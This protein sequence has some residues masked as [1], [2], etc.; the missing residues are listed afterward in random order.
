MVLVVQHRRFLT[1]L[2]WT[3]K[4]GEYHHHQNEEERKRL[5]GRASQ[6]TESFFFS[7][8]LLTCVSHFIFFD[9]TTSR[10]LDFKHPLMVAFLFRASFSDFLFFFSRAVCLYLF[11]FL[12]ESFACNL[13]QANSLIH[14]TYY[15]LSTLWLANAK[16]YYS[17]FFFNV[18]FISLSKDKSAMKLKLNFRP[19][20]LDFRDTF[21]LV[22]VKRI[23][24]HCLIKFEFWCINWYPQWKWLKFGPCLAGRYWILYLQ[25]LV[26][27][28]T[29]MKCVTYI[30][31]VERFN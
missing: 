27:K 5:I 28:N 21:S 22:I 26:Y 24:W 8:S 23:L 14:K 30:V 15:K 6:Q 7:L 1:I 3:H 16:F 4:K 12:P 25:I 20:N 2:N 11:A 13:S 19:L 10:S 18:F 9:I 17:Q 31:G 29:L